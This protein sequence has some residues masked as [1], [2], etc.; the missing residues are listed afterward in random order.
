MHSVCKGYTKGGF[1]SEDTGEFFR[2][3][4]KYSKSLSWAWN[5]NKLFTVFGRKF[6]F[7]G[8]DKGQLIS[9]CF[10]WCLRFLPK[11]EQKQVDLRY[12]GGKVKFVYSF[13]GRIIGLKK[14]SWLCLT[15]S[16]LNIFWG[17]LTNSLHFLKKDAFTTISSLEKR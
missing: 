6:E 10:F 4:H 11:N 8:Q 17:D 2:C 9:K 5:L 12:H 14:S 15:F 16:D 3:K 13:F 7:Q 1:K